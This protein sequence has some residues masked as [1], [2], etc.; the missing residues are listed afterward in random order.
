MPH[1][2]GA[3]P[4]SWIPSSSPGGSPAGHEA[5]GG[6]RSATPRGRVWPCAGE[7][8]PA[9]RQHPPP[10]PGRARVRRRRPAPSLRVPRSRAGSSLWPVREPRRTRRAVSGHCRPR[11]RAGAGGPCAL[12]RCRVVRGGGVMRCA[13]RRVRPGEAAGGR[14]PPAPAAPDRRPAG[15]RRRAVPARE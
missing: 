5:A 10:G 3:W 6:A 1:G 11:P 4:V 12:R 15:P 7:W 14:A 13:G 9:F 8:H 2:E